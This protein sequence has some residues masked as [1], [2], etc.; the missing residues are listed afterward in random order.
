MVESNVVLDEECVNAVQE[1]VH[2]AKQVLVLSIILEEF[3]KELSRPSQ[4]RMN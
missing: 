2:D 4:T 1:V 3:I